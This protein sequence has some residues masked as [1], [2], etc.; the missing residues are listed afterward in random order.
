MS[1]RDDLVDFTGDETWLF[2][3]PERFD[4]AILG[5]VEGIGRTDVVCYDKG[6]VLRILMEDGMS[7]EEAGEYYNFNMLGAY[8]GEKTPVFLEVL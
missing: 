2:M 8:V 4:A 3:D 1:K 7:W 6:K 5:Y